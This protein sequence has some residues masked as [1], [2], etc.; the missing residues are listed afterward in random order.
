TGL[1]LP[2]VLLA[3]LRAALDDRVRTLD[4]SA[5]AARTQALRERV[6]ASLREQFDVM[7]DDAR[8]AYGLRDAHSSGCEMWTMGL[9]RACLLEAGRR[10][11]ARG[12]LLEAEHVLELRHAEV[13]G[14][15][16]GTS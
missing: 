1:E 13:L 9:A 15:L 7:L 5:V 11:L 16:A 12:L 3:S 8:S 14:A 2:N 4:A 6:D 10:L